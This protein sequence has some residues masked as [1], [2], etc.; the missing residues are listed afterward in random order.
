M[1]QPPN[2]FVP[3]TLAATLATV[4]RELVPAAETIE[5]ISTNQWYVSKPTALSCKEVAVK[6]T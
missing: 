6:L 5:V 2:L 1:D 3:P 4:K